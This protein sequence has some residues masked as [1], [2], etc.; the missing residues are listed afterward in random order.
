MSNLTL[1]YY[2][3]EQEGRYTEIKEQSSSTIGFDSIQARQLCNYLTVNNVR[4]KILSKEIKNTEEVVIMEKV[5]NAKAFEDEL[6]N[7][8]V[9]KVKIEFRPSHEEED[10]SLVYHIVLSGHDEAFRYL[11]KDAIEIEGQGRCKISSLEWDEDRSVY[12][13]YFKPEKDE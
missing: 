9:S 1:K 3:K 11:N 8:D 13:V 5:G 7:I 10:M 12:V 6:I 2:I 4:Y